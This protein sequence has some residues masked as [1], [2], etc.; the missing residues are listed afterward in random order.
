M[1]STWQV[2]VQD[3]KLIHK[4]GLFSDSNRNILKKCFFLPV[5]LASAELD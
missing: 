5:V 2:L 1:A 4:C 3:E